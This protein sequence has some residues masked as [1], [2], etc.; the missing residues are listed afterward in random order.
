M[1][2]TWPWCAIST[3]ELPATH[4]SARSQGPKSVS[5]ACN[6]TVT[7]SLV[8]PAEV[9]ERRANATTEPRTLMVQG[10]SHSPGAQSTSCSRLGTQLDHP[11]DRPG[12]LPAG[13][14]IQE[15]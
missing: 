9:A 7:R 1:A 14:L 13:A 6:T 10:Y 12:T 4:G 3:L 8:A 15:R 2:W 5:T 11:I